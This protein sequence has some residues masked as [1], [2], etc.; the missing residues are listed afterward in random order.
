MISILRWAWTGIRAGIAA[1]FVAGV[2]LHVV[3]LLSFRHLFDNVEAFIIPPLLYAANLALILGAFGLAA[4]LFW[5]GVAAAR[6]RETRPGERSAVCAA[7]CF[8]AAAG[9]FA[10]LWIGVRA[11][12][13]LDVKTL[14]ALLGVCAGCVLL[15]LLL[16]R[17]PF[18]AAMRP[19]VP[20]TGVALTLVFIAAAAVAIASRSGVEHLCEPPHGMA[21]PPVPGERATAEPGMPN[22]LLITVDTLRANHLGCYG[23]G[24]H[25]SPAIDSLAAHGVLVTK[26]YAQRPKT[27]PN[28]ATILTG[29]YP[30]RHGVRGVSRPLP[31][32]AY[33]LAESLHDQGFRT[34]GVVTNGNLFPAFKF[35]Q[36]F[37]EYFYGHSL[38]GEGTE[39][40]QRWLR[41]GGPSPFFLW[42]HHTDPHTP[43]TPPSPY[44]R[45][46]TH[47]GDAAGKPLKIIKRR[48]L[49]GVLP[50]KIIDG[51]LDLG[52][53]IAQYDGEVAY[54]DHCIG[55]LLWTL[56]DLGLAENTL[57]IFTADHG[58][59]LGD[60]DYYFQHGLFTYEP[61]ARVPLAFCWPGSLMAAVE[62]DFLFESVDIMPT[63]L[64]LVG[65]RVPATCQGVSRAAV[66]RDPGRGA[67]GTGRRADEAD[68]YAYIEAGYSHNYGP[69]LTFALVGGRYKLVVRDSAWAIHPLRAKEFLNSMVAFLETGVDPNE[70]YDIEND[71]EEKNNLIE[72]RPEVAA[73]LKAELASL[74]AR[75]ENEGRLPK[76]TETQ[77]L[78]E[79][80]LKS[81]KAL[82]YIK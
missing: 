48:A 11:F 50:N 29:T 61:S 3:I 37:E 77:D 58:E 41:E 7:T 10:S 78:D 33:T 23:Y 20:S 14:A 39:I 70:L 65:A 40:A 2:T 60:H 55:E 26:A 75:L 72:V 44:D 56:R 53:Y 82:G 1:A 6:R 45:L 27:S 42:V 28:F 76:D 62:S 64:D 34:C 47:E 17:R 25:T 5:G 74:L 57:V 32:S 12:P 18:V 51:P 16:T 31:A 36:G 46:F 30:Q 35:D 68:R 24:R 79:Q 63:I 8:P 43:Y 21:G 59:S 73:L 4:G 38:A 67:R 9:F 71:P 49:G 69:G 52:H 66:M 15:V 54:T 81:L 80:T 19:A 22:V 13:D